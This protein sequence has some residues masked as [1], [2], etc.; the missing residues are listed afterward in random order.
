MDYRTFIA[1]EDAPS[2]NAG[3]VY[4]WENDPNGK[5]PGPF[6]LNGGTGGN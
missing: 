5:I 6:G 3:E 4:D 2:V 1:D